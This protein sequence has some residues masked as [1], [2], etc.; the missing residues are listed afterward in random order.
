MTFVR[1]PSLSTI[2]DT[3]VILVA[4]LVGFSFF[5]ILRT[6]LKIFLVLRFQFS[7]CSSLMIL[8]FIRA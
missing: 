3:N 8:T 5:F 2:S 7:F 1:F 6:E 4:R